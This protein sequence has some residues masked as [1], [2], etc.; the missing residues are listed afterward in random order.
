MLVAVSATDELILNNLFEVN[1]AV[2]VD[3]ASLYKMRSAF[4]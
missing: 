1:K 3:N 4:S 2:K